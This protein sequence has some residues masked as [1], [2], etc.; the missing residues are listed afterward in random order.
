LQSPEVLEKYKTLL[1]G[2][3][4]LKLINKEEIKQEIK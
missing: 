1:N 2:Q 4:K 3:T